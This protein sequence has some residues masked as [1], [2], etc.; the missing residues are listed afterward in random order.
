LSN[1]G[2]YG[3][4]YPLVFMTDDSCAERQALQQVF[5]KSTLLLCAFHVCQA[6]WIWLWD[7]KHKINQFERQSLMTKFRDVLFDF[8]EENALIGIEE[9][10]AHP[11]K[12]FADHMVK[13]KNRM[14][15]WAI[16][17]RK[18]LNIHGKIQ[19]ILLSHQYEF[20]KILYWNDAK[21]SMQQL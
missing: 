2:F 17:Y 4:K 1:I 15:E 18:D 20:L 6:L 16:C 3:Q 19:I 21:H 14:S 11:N 12:L 13:L 8:Y 10:C 7:T 5:P 9:L